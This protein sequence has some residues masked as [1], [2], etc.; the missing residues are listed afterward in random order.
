MDTQTVETLL[1]DL[2]GRRRV[3][4]DEVRRERIR[5]WEMSAVERLHLPTG[6]TVIFKYAA[7]PFAREHLVLRHCYHE[8]LPVPRV[9][10][11]SPAYSPGGD[12][13][14]H[15][16]M[17]LDDLGQP[18][19]TASLG[20]A[21]RM[22]VRVHAVRPMHG[23]TVLGLGGLAGLP[24]QAL[25]HLEDLQSAGRWQDP[26]LAMLLQALERVADDRARGATI[27]PYGMV[28]SEWH[29][30][31]LLA[32]SEVWVLD[33]A[34]AFTGSGLLDLASWQGTTTAPDPDAL[35][36]LIALYIGSGGAASA[37]DNRAGLPAE[38]WALG[39]HRIEAVAWFI[40][41]ALRWLRPDPDQDAAGSAVVVRHLT[42]AVELLRA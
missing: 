18:E 1:A 31:S 26:Q 7:G 25:D 3:G 21:A 41:Q 5:S 17:L 19:R 6:E 13:L 9:R 12:I 24:R 36:D 29:P 35:R 34:R 32:T 22:A 27:P 14:D 16:G 11:A 10:D 30:T 33:M 28:H 37:L 8:G 15:M 39:W 40:E 38:L 42:E 20:D 23:R 2:L 4:V